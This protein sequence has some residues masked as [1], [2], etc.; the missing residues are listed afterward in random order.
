MPIP[1]KNF[2]FIT[3]NIE[4]WN[5]SIIE[6]NNSIHWKEKHRIRFNKGIQKIDFDKNYTQEFPYFSIFSN[7]P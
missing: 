5:F 6:G 7:V 4:S 2:C 3:G 1:N